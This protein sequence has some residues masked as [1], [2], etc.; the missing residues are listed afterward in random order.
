MSH[1]KLHTL[2]LKIAGARDAAGAGGGR[3]RAAVQVVRRSGIQG[4]RL[5]QVHVSLRLQ[6]LLEVRRRECGL[7]LHG[8]RARVCRPE[9]EGEG[10]GL[11][12]KGQAEAVALAAVTILLL[13]RGV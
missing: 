1:R 11:A 6:V 13:L 2:S 4:G 8:A 3:G 12:C 5:R 10:R 7:P 9:G